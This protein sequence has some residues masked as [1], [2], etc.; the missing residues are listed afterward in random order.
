MNR[1]VLFP[2]MIFLCISV[3]PSRA[4]S[5]DQAWFELVGFSPNGEY[6][7][8]ETGGIQDGSGFQWISAEVLNSQTSIQEER[9]SHVWDDCIDESPDLADLHSIEEKIAEIW[10]DRGIESDIYFEP[11]VYYPLTD[12]GVSRDT[13]VFCLQNYVPDYHSSE[14]T[15]TLANKPA[16]IPQDY[17]DWFPPPVTPVLEISMNEEEY[18]FFKEDPIS[19]SW[20]MSMSYGIYAVYSNPYLSEN[21]VVVLASTGPGFEGPNG[22]FR[23]ITGS[24]RSSL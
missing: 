6:V 12:L 15:L 19:E 3:F 23:V 7:A 18:I 14:I 11:L 24:L 10:S 16:G 4:Y 9:F 21:L 1:I 22:R 17:P 2:I 8:W 5:G 20:G 13:V